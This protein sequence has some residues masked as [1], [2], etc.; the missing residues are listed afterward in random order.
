MKTAILATVGIAGSFLASLWGGWD[1]ALETLVLFMGIDYLCGLIVAAVFHKSEKSENGALESRAG[2]KGLIRKG[3]V[4]L[5]VLIG[6]RLDL[7]IGGPVI[8]HT[9]TRDAVCIAFTTNE[10]ISIIENIGVMGVPVPAV[11]TKAIDVL[12]K[13]ADEKKEKDGGEG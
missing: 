7:V 12:Q 5:V 4:L 2:F 11:I 10:L 1:L 9:L 13:K 6:H 8:G 3:A